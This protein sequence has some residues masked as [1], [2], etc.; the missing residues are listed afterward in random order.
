MTLFL[1]PTE[2]F[3]LSHKLVD[4]YPNNPVSFHHT[5]RCLSRLLFLKVRHL[6]EIFLL[7]FLVCSRVLLSHGWPQKRA[8]SPISEVCTFTRT[9]WWTDFLY[10]ACQVLRR[11]FK[12]MH[13]VC[14][15]QQSHHAGED[16]RAGVDRI[17]TFFRSGERA[18]PSHGSLLHSCP[19]DERVGRL[20][21]SLWFRWKIGFLHL[22]LYFDQ[23]SD[24]KSQIK[25]K[26]WCQCL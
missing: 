17:R 16:V 18:R 24:Q 21:D 3:Y 26:E 8:C 7:G 1:P 12:N 25:L 22:E 5:T 19:A 10:V 4:L 9:P 11:C 20:F 15:L 13:F 14:A 23:C 2:L 6:K